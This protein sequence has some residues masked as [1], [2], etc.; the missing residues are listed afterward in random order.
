MSLFR[1]IIERLR[2]PGSRNGKADYSIFLY[3]LL[4][5]FLFPR[6]FAEM[7]QSYKQF[8]VLWLYLALLLAVAGIAYCYLT[9]G[10]RPWDCILTV[11]AYYTILL[12]STLLYQRG[13]HEGLQKL[14]A[15]PVLYLLCLCCW[16]RDS[17]RFLHILANILIVGFFLDLT[18]FNQRVM[19][20]LTGEIH[21]AFI[22]HVQLAAQ[23]GTL[24]ILVG[25]LLWKLHPDDEV[26]AVLLLVLSVLSILAADTSAGTLVLMIF[27]FGL[28]IRRI[29]LLRPLLR[30]HPGAYL[31]CYLLLN[32]VV[33]LYSGSGL[34]AHL[35][36]DT[37]TFNGRVYIWGEGIRLWMQRPLSGYG[38]YGV[39][40]HTPWDS[41]MNYAHNELLQ[42]LLDCGML[43]CIA[44][45][46]LMFTTVRPAARIRNL[47]TREFFNLCLVAMLFI[48]VFE[49]VTEYYV[50]AIFLTIFA[51]APQ[52]VGQDNI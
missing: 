34:G 48:M 26:R 12:L 13:I 49:S 16:R 21:L 2:N 7:Y 27:A 41:S 37:L 44:F 9:D 11:G 20:Y 42:R 43:G 22:G 25:Y 3:F 30:W 31:G 24:G 28:L 39:Q 40:I 17:K 29:P 36:G 51:C 10:F 5:P 8:F 4:V 46:A 15:A 47:A 23:L 52:I 45:L 38:V 19:L 14:F 35:G 1:T 32:L 50:I 18:V 33:F 6:G